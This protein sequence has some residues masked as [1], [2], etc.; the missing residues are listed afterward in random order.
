MARYGLLRKLV[1][2]KRRALLKRSSRSRS[3]RLL[4]YKKKK[5]LLYKKKKYR[6]YARLTPPIKGRGTRKN[7]K[8]ARFTNKGKLSLQARLQSGGSLPMQ[9][10]ARFYWRGSGTIAYSNES[11]LDQVFTLNDLNKQANS[12]FLDNS[13]I[14]FKGAFSYR[15]LW[16]TLYKEALILGSKAKFRISKPAY[17]SGIAGSSTVVG[18]PDQDGTIRYLGQNALPP[19]M[20]YGF[21]YL[22]YYYFRS[23]DDPAGGGA[24]LVARQV[25]HD[26][27]TPDYQLWGNMRD[28]M[29]DSSVTWIRDKLPKVTKMGYQF[30]NAMG[31]ALNVDQN[32]PLFYGANSA[33]PENRRPQGI[34]YELE[35]S[36]RPINFYP[37][38]SAKKHLA[39]TNILRNGKWQDMSLAQTIAGQYGPEHE[40]RVKLGYVGFDATGTQVINI[41]IDRI[42]KRQ[43]E[44]EIQYFVALRHPKV[45]PWGPHERRGHNDIPPVPPAAGR[46]LLVAGTGEHPDVDE[47]LLSI[48][49][50]DDLNEIEDSE[51]EDLLDLVDQDPDV[52]TRGDEEGLADD[53]TILE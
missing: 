18:V 39:Q 1:K 48:H 2:R 49:D 22:R 44:V 11:Q 35:F 29:A 27:A 37:K 26:V 6:K 51:L 52:S 25:G 23:K 7:F 5:L 21:W 15:P 10:F 43:V 45:E 36:N 53:G 20:V 50:D 19:D 31:G 13:D 16:S 38:Y 41:P 34:Y 4:A 17:P 3:R 9:T 32:G 12:A 42:Y 47:D 33:T 30:S 28:F 46:H 8:K 40:F 14:N 24:D